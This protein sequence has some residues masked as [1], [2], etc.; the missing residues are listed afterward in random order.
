[1]WCAN[2]FCCADHSL[3]GGPRVKSMVS[4]LS[5][6]E[7]SAFIGHAH[8]DTVMRDHRTPDDGT[9]DF[10]NRVDHEFPLPRLHVFVEYDHDRLPLDH[11]F[12][13]GLQ[14]EPDSILHSP[15]APDREMECRRVCEEGPLLAVSDDDG[16][17]EIQFSHSFS[18]TSADCIEM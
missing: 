18:D 5:D 4:P 9:L 14:H 10:T 16:R 6:H 8:R 2:G 1:M 17:M 15:G 7:R 12:V 11:H 3:P 13:P